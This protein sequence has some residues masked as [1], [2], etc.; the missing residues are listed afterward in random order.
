MLY[1][2]IQE[3]IFFIAQLLALQPHADRLEVEA[4]P[5]D[6]IVVL[7]DRAVPGDANI[8]LLDLGPRHL[9]VAQHI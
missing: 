4:V 7:G 2:A 1:N 9:H 6:G 3:V 5:H 8:V